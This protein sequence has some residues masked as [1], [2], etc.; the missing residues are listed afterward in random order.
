[1]IV[2]I[3]ILSAIKGLLVLYFHNSLILHVI[4]RQIMFEYYINYICYYI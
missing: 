2:I 4:I 1:M 3:Y